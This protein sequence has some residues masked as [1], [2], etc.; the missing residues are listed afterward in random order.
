MAKAKTEKTEAIPNIVRVER[1]T[2]YGLRKSNGEYLYKVWYE[3]EKS[4]YIWAE[5][6]LQAYQR[7]MRD[8]T[9]TTV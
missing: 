2:F 8:E 4:E 6:E 3:D 1:D 7:V 5:D 9:E